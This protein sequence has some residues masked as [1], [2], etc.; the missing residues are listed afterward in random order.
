MDRERAGG[1]LTCGGVAGMGAILV[2]IAGGAGAAAS[3]GL[4][5]PRPTVRPDPEA[6]VHWLDRKRPR[7][8]PVLPGRFGRHTDDDPLAHDRRTA[9]L[10]IVEDQPGIHVGAVV[11]E[12]EISRS[13]VRHHVRVLESAE[14]LETAKLLGRRRLFPPGADEAF[15]ASLADEGSSRVVEAVA[16][17]GPAPTGRIVEVTDKAHSTVSYHLDRL[18]SAG[19]VERERDGRRVYVRLADEVADTLPGAETVAAD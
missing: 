19:V 10:D 3:V 9:L 8:P 4:S 17:V 7:L 6:L 12:M 13:S 11:D 2:G 15:L 16:E 14:E 5:I 18:E 1:C